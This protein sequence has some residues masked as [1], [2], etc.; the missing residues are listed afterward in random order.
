MG[1][2]RHLGRIITL[3]TLYEQ[4]FR[5][6]CDDKSLKQDE[7]L[8]RGIGRYK[9]QVKETEFIHKLVTGVTEN[10]QYLDGLLQV[11]ATEWPLDQIPRMDLIILRIASY[12][13]LFM[14]KST[15]TSVVINEAVE[16]AKSFGGDNSSK[17]INGVLGSLARDLEKGNVLRPK[18]SSK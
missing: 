14:H 13:L 2:N 6:D 7:I 17:F 5:E 8:E 16:L 1:S 9:K 10:F 3:Q 18:E 15:P 4:S 12:E 11:F